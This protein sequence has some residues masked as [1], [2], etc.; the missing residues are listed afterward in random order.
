MAGTDLQVV[1][2]EALGCMKCRLAEGRTQVV[3]G[4]GDPGSDLVIVGEAPGANEDLSGLPFVGRSGELLDRVL[5][6]EVGRDRS[7]LYITNIVKCRPEANRD[8]RRDEVEACRPYL[9]RQLQVIQPRVVVTLGNFAS[10][11]L[12]DTTTGI[13]RLRGAVYPLKGWG[14]A[15]GTVVVPTYHPAA[16]LRGG[17]RVE[18]DLRVDLRLAASELRRAVPV[19]ANPTEAAS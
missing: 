15:E 12:L 17:R 18:G 5:A 11:L 10:R 13:T 1:R 2:T 7:E 19:V 3:F 16:A 9:V 8:P 4:S 6:E 14:P